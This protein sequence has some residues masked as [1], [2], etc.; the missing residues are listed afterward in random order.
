MK[1]LYGPKACRTSTQRSEIYIIISNANTNAK[2]K[3]F[4]PLKEQRTGDTTAGQR[5]RFPFL[6][7]IK[8]FALKNISDEDEL[9]GPGGTRCQDGC[10]EGPRRGLWVPGLQGRREGEREGGGEKEKGEDKGMRR[11]TRHA[12]PN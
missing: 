2:I 5:I 12:S 11:D 8:L 10:Q 9:R 1:D 6:T 7:K 4:N 3:C